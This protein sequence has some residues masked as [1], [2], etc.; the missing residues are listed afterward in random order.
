MT[1]N[2]TEIA[3]MIASYFAEHGEDNEDI[4]AATVDQ[5][6]F[7][8]RGWVSK[9]NDDFA[10]ATVYNIRRMH[11][12]GAITVAVKCGDRIADFDIAAIIKHAERPLFGGRIV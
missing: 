12:S 6:W 7:T 9:R 11:R 10:R 3:D 8:R 1:N 2:V 5:A 4:Q